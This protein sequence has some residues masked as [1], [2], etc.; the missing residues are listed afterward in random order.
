MNDVRVRM[1][2][3]VL[4]A[5]FVGCS[6]GDGNTVGSSSGLPRSSTVASLTQTEFGTLCD[7]TNA[8]QGGYGRSMMCSD[9]SEET[10]DA[11]KAY[12]VA[13]FP[14]VAQ[15]CPTLTVADLEDCA[16]ATGTNL[17]AYP[18]AAGCANA[19]ACLD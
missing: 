4:V 7:W 5:T 3:L 6:G 19:R 12:C 13:A 14:L 8:K 1:A 2:V 10:T 18:T 11:D 17:C 9:G 15:Y 16:N